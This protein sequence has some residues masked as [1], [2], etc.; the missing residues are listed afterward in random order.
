M[1]TLSLQAAHERL[2]EP[3]PVLLMTTDGFILAGNLLAM[4]LWNT[5]QIERFFGAHIID[6]VSRNFERIPIDSNSNTYANKAVILT[7]LRDKFGEEPYYHYLEAQH[8]NPDEYP[9]DINDFGRMIHAPAWAKKGGHAEWLLWL[10]R[11][12]AR[13]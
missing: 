8:Q 7:D 2:K 10:S 12:D 11:L 1:P 9:L 3:Y 13:K 6:I 4:W 5:P